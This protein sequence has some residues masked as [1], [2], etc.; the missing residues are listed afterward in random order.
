[1]LIQKFTT[2][3]LASLGLHRSRCFYGDRIVEDVTH[4]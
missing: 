3:V 4:S 2:G 1:M